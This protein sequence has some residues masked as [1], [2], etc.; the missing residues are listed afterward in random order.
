MLLSQNK[1][2]REKYI[3]IYKKK[4]GKKSFAPKQRLGGTA[5]ACQKRKT[6]DRVVYISMDHVCP[7]QIESNTCWKLREVRKWNQV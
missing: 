5:H 7:Y 6:C 4:K 3:S 2:G 1:V